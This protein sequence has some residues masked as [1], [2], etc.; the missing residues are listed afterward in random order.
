[1]A[2]EI[3]ESENQIVA[4]S[5]R[6]SLA[7]WANES[8]EWIRRIVRHILESEDPIS[9]EG[10]ALTYQLLLEENEI[11]DRAL[12]AEPASTTTTALGWR[13]HPAFTAGGAASFVGAARPLVA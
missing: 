3:A 5:P 2:N 7:K 8:D 6:D 4:Q 13:L 10:I 9:S 11:E 12:P 1:M